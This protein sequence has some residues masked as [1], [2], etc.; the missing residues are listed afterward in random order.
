MKS[1]T[2]FPIAAA[3]ILFALAGWMLASQRQPSLPTSA[4][5]KMGLVWTE[6]AMTGGPDWRKA[7][8]CLGHPMPIWDELDKSP[9]GERFGYEG[10]RLTIGRDAY[11][12]NLSGGFFGWERYTL[13][14]NGRAMRSL[15]G[16]FTAFS[17]NVSLQ[18]VGGKAA[19]E[20]ADGEE[21]A[22]IIFDGADLRRLYGLDKAYRPYG[23]GDKLIFVGETDGKQFI[24]YDGHKIG[25]D[26]DFIYIAYCC[27]P[28]LWSVAVAQGKYVFWAERGGQLY[29][30]EVALPEE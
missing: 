7:E 11:E 18:N 1:K 5:E 15:Y 13:Y 8:P 21:T 22:T 12:T 20:F 29:L 6:C 28:V 4:P 14:K 3:L 17:P 19:W 30:V 23:L 24:V 27:E 9:F 2:V 26:F 25:H 10:I 16:Q